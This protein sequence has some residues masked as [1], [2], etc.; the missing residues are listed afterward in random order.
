LY[1]LIGNLN[2][3]PNGGRFI[4][5]G[6]HPES[7]P[8]NYAPNDPF[9]MDKVY[10]L[11]L[12][13]FQWIEA[14][15][16]SGTTRSFHQCQVIGQRQML[17][18]GGQP[19]KW[20]SSD[21]NLSAQDP[22]ANGLA[23]FDMSELT[24]SFDYDANAAAYTPATLVSD[25]YETSSRYP[26]FNDAALT[27]IF[28]STTASTT[29]SSTASTSTASNTASHT[30]AKKPSALKSSHTGA[31]VG[32]VVGG[33]AVI[34]LLAGV[35]YLFLRRRRR[36]EYSHANVEP[37]AEMDTGL[38]PEMDEQRRPSEMYNQQE[39]DRRTAAELR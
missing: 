24:W 31:I 32:G 9:D 17:S 39:H 6:D 30:P 16:T 13:A 25:Y 19:M 8:T 18:I 22:W 4:Y 26:S 29:A 3:L 15:G 12:P 5:G 34:S 2:S 37:L 11:T 28:N 23:I 38:R 27:A 21:S 20:T 10:I 33:V 35:C 36:Q 14:P 7:G 1:W